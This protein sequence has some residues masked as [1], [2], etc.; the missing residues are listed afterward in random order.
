M[1]TYN[2]KIPIDVLVGTYIK[3]VLQIDYDNITNL[4]MDIEPDGN[5]SIQFKLEDKGW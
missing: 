1:S 4:G 5:I 2:A 3:Y